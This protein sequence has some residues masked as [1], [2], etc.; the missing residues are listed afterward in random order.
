M[1]VC[2]VSRQSRGINN[3]I[4]DL[5][6]GRAKINFRLMREYYSAHVY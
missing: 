1:Q 2:E 6:A 3:N 4:T 5:Y